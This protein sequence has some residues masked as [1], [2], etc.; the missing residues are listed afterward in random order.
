LCNLERISA[1]LEIIV[2]QSED[3][4]EWPDA[5]PDDNVAELS[6]HLRV[7]GCSVSYRFNITVRGCLT[8]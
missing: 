3:W 6:D 5:R 7:V 8:Y 2:D 1:D 4:G